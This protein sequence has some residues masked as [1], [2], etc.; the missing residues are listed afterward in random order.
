[1]LKIA[2]RIKAVR[3]PYAALKLCSRNS[4]RI[5]QTD[6][7]FS[8]YNLYHGATTLNVLHPSFVFQI[9]APRPFLCLTSR[10][11]AYICG[12][13]R[14]RVLI[15]S[16]A[17]LFDLEQCVFRSKREHSSYINRLAVLEN[18]AQHFTGS[19]APRSLGY[20]ALYVN[21]QRKSGREVTGVSCHK[22]YYLT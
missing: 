7:L 22:V 6:L 1:M 18:A 3:S 10:R 9:V 19:I 5:V 4:I 15:Q 21:R 16:V 2:E 17:Y 14:Y 20:R 13:L 11:Y 8:Q 12:Q